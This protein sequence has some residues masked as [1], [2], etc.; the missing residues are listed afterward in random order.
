[1]KCS[2]CAAQAEYGADVMRGGIP[3]W[4][5][6][7]CSG[8]MAVLVRECLEGGSDAPRILWLGEL[9][10][11]GLDD[12]PQCDCHLRIAGGHFEDCPELV[13]GFFRHTPPSPLT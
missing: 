2:Y 3:L 8:D 6:R 10:A 11:L 4:G 5:L 7:L 9:S 13:Q 1:M 12:A